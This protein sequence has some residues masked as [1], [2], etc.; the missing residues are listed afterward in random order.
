MRAHW[1]CNTKAVSS[2]V[3][4]LFLPL[5]RQLL[6]EETNGVEMPAE[7]TPELYRMSMWQV[8]KWCL[9]HPWIDQDDVISAVHERLTIALDKYDPDGGSKV[10][11]WL[12]RATFH[13][14]VD[15]AKRA[16]RSKRQALKFSEIET[17]EYKI[18][19]RAEFSVKIP[20]SE[21]I[22]LSDIIKN[23][24][25]KLTKR[26]RQAFDRIVYLEYQVE[27]YPSR[28]AYESDRQYLEKAIE[29]LRK[30][31]E[32]SVYNVGDSLLCKHC[33]KPFQR[34]KYD[35]MWKYKNK[36]KF[37]SPQCHYEHISQKNISKK[38]EYCG[39]IIPRGN[40]KMSNFKKLKACSE[41]C[42]NALRIISR[43]VSTNAN[44][45]VKKCPVCGK[46]FGSTPEKPRSINR[47]N[48]C[49]KTCGLIMSWQVNNRT[50]KPLS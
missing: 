11:S 8:K 14:I 47:A 30:E 1:R 29:K 20:F 19:N 42:T 39:K 28:S 12:A 24:F 10:T 43:M 38:C 7:L 15:A 31:P 5:A 23:R 34:K 9:S 2:H 13:G 40:M 17:D 46:Y 4:F 35:K 48:C 41:E 49:S 21:R 36:R 44:C 33:G 32:I 27:D 50:P 16:S 26:Q 37:C 45:W 6:R 25:K 18:D 22:I 3:G